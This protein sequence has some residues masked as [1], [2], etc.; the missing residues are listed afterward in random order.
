MT[1]QNYSRYFMLFLLI[2][3]SQ[4]LFQSKVFAC[5]YSNGSSGPA[6][7]NINLGNIVVNNDTDM[8]VGTVMATKEGTMASLG[9]MLPS[10]ACGNASQT[11]IAYVSIFVGANPNSTAT[12]YPTNIPGVGVKLYYY[13]TSAYQYEPLTPTQAEF[14]FSILIQHGATSIY[15]NPNAALK[16]E[17]VKTASI[18]DIDAGALLYQSP[19]FL[20]VDQPGTKLASVNVSANITLSTCTLVKYDSNI[21]LQQVSIPELV[22][23]G[24]GRY[25][26]SAPFKFNL[27]CSEG[28]V[29]K[30]KFTGTTMSDNNQVLANGDTSNSNIGVQIEN[31][32]SNQT[33]EFGVP[34]VAV[35]DAI[36]NQDL[37]FNTY[38]YYRGGNLEAGKVNS[39]ATF[40]LTYE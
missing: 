26:A 14:Q 25:S 17:L 15:Q 37:T 29:V 16:V 6:V 36:G 30:A 18:R 1:R 13:S 11:N 23:N 20:T 34:F 19:N 7:L 31:T 39:T 24:I 28:T 9:G 8:P 12:T 21:T 33:V 27:K 4:I 2:V 22:S 38:Y 32:N 40:E 5:Y 3:F 10:F 35:N